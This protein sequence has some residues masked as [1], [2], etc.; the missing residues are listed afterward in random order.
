M[1]IAPDEPSQCITEFIAGP[2]D[3]AML[4]SN[5][6]PTIES[7]LYWKHGM[8]LKL[9][10]YEGLNRRVSSL[11]NNVNY[12]SPLMGKYTRKPQGINHI[13]VYV[14][15]KDRHAY[16][17]AGLYPVKDILNLGKIR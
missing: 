11:V 2:A 16:I 5:R 17:Y 15:Y 8:R 14:E 12:Q 9:Q 4:S 1:A 7:L 13:Y 6:P 10:S 3:G